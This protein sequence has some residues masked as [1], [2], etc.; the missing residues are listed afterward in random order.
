M[1]KGDHFHFI[2]Y[3]STADLLQPRQ[4]DVLH[5]N[6]VQWTKCSKHIG[7]MERWQLAGQ[8]RSMLQSTELRMVTEET[9]YNNKW[10]KW[11]VVELMYC[12]THLHGERQ[13]N[14]EREREVRRYQHLP[15]RLWR[16]IAAACMAS[17]FAQCIPNTEQ[18]TASTLQSWQLETWQRKSRMTYKASGKSALIFLEKS[19]SFCFHVFCVFSRSRRVKENC[20]VV[21]KKNSF[22]VGGGKKTRRKLRKYK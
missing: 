13:H 21:G 6:V 14:G 5:V 16:A 2:H 12:C 1:V 11:S 7:F 20:T 8:R 15:R 22:R 3:I 19:C 9:Y 4:C 18:Q 17:W 10:D